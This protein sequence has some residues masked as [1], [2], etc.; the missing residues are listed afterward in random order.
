[1][2]TL[3]PSLTRTTKNAKDTAQPAVKPAAKTSDEKARRVVA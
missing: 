1:M 3:L 2:M